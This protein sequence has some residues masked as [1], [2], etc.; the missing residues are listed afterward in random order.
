MSGLP[1]PL[2][3]AA[4]QP[5]LRAGDLASNAAAHA[6]AI[7]EAGA[8]LV[9]FP[10]LSLSSYA[11]A[12]PAV[13]LADPALDGIIAAC[14][15]TGSVALAGAPVAEDGGEYIATLRIDGEGV[16]VA[17]RKVHPDEEES[18]RF[19]AARDHVVL[20]LDGWRLGLA[21]CRDTMMF[22]HAPATAEFAKRS[23]LGGIDAYIAGSLYT[24]RGLPRRDRRMPQI[25]RGYGIWVVQACFAGPGS[26]YPEAV[27]NSAIWSPDGEVAARADERPGRIVKAEMGFG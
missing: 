26:D 6:E 22:E 8:R 20:E 15:E 27:G 21:I 1:R 18:R 14:A 3:V 12:A 9:V 23:G 7:R 13:A 16:A 24:P 4:A 17:Y 11:M 25:A 10:E 2:T 19:R 5:L